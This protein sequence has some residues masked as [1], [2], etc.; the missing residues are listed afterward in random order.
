MV[1]T[2]A[3]SAFKVLS[4]CKTLS[5]A[6]SFRPL[7]MAT[8]TDSNPALAAA[9]DLAHTKLPNALVV[10]GLGLV[11][12]GLKGLGTSCLRLT[13]HFES[14]GVGG[15]SNVGLGTT[16]GDPGLRLWLLGLELVGGD[17]LAS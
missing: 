17:A 9:A 8:S 5:I 16:R 13:I 14:L 4:G 12:E 11:P 6:M 15:S 2:A 7:I 1:C 10:F 3:A